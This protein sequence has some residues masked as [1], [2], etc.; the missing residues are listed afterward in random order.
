MKR[1]FQL[2]V[3][4]LLAVTCGYAQSTYEAMEDS[5]NMSIDN[6]DFTIMES[7]LG[8]DDD[9]TSDVIQVG[10]SSNLYT[11]NIGWTW[12][13]ARFKF[14][15]LD[16]KYNDVYINGVLANQVENGR[17]QFSNIG[18]MNDAARN[19][20]ASNPFE[21]N[22]FAMPGLGGATNYD[23]RASSMSTGS[24]LTLSGLNRNY[25]VR[26]MFSHGTGLSKNG[27]ALYGSLAYRWGNMETAAVDGT[28]YNS[29]SYLLSL[30][31][32]WDN[33][34]SLNLAT[35]GNPTERAQQGASTDEAYWLAN[36]RL[37]NPYW[38]FQNGR[39]RSSRIVNDFAPTA[40]LTWDYQINDKMKLTTSAMMRYQL[41]SSTKLDYSGTNPAPDYWK[42][43]PSYN[44]D[45]WGTT[46]GSNNNIEAYYTAKDH[47]QSG[48]QARQIN[49]D[50]LYFAN[51]QLNKTGSDAIYWI[52]AR[53]NDHLT[54][55]LGSNFNWN[56]DKTSKINIGIQLSN[57]TGMHY[58]T[59][60]DLLGGEYFHNVDRHLVGTFVETDPRADYDLNNRNRVVR[61]GDRYGYDYNIMVQ[62]FNA[63]ASYTKNIGKA[64]NYL[65]ARLGGT[66][67]WRDGKMKNGLFA[68]NSYGESEAAGFI[69]GG[70]KFASTLNLG[71][72]HSI[73]IGGGFEAKTP[74]ARDAFIC[75]EKNNDFVYTLKYTDAYIAKHGLDN[76]NNLTKVMVDGKYMENMYVERDVV[77]TAGLQEGMD[78]TKESNLKN[79]KIV[80]SELKYS[81]NNRWLRLDLTGYF[82][83]KYDGTEWG[84][85]YDDNESNFMYV[86]SQNV[87]KRN[88]GVE[89]AAKFKVTSNFDITLLG[90]YS[91][92]EIV[93]NTSVT[94]MRSDKEN[95]TTSPCFANGMR[96]SGTP[97]AAASLSLNYKIKGWY[98][99]LTGNYYD[100]IYLSYTT[101]PRQLDVQSLWVQ[102]SYGGAYTDVDGT[103]ICAIPEQAKGKGGFVLDASIGK[104]FYFGKNPLSVNLN[105]SN[106]T[107][108]TSLCTGGYEQSRMNYSVNNGEMS[109]RTYNF[110]KNPKKYY[111]QG[112]NF[113]INV[114]YRF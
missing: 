79:E 53:H 44:Y 68:D 24:K 110:L 3:L 20:D 59:L 75:P 109:N 10:S 17:F 6:D 77:R 23:F 81:I 9:M 105:L 41:Y 72:G 12:S 8:E 29:L 114:N 11:S 30:Q 58:Q 91:E 51:Q 35:W 90:T 48:V 4:A 25:T 46:D 1:K 61:E 97:L 106:I 78:Y 103:S 71:S 74:S 22:T 18:G 21:S 37:Y 14:R 36:D 94:S 102:N 107:N 73:S 54:A 93:G 112:F 38:G 28:F 104:Q 31:K 70:V 85:F 15:A 40:L 95:I 7:Q 65:V 83:Y 39:K 60:E 16:N 84:C 49:F 64:H 50:E 13:A 5:T 45:V 47:W 57:T 33:G 32:K 86:S 92:A 80:S 88:Y 82:S 52:Q 19:K 56:I 111:A 100:R 66:R 98:L 101:I 63:Y 67:M 62:K 42:N 76:T 113:M 89:L 34:H 55:S 87:T 69:D 26:G 27:W 43:F 96:E 108:N 99:G 2:T